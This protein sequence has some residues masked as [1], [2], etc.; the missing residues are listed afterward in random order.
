MT[1]TRKKLKIN[2]RV[3][4]FIIHGAIRARL[5]PWNHFPRRFFV[6]LSEFPS[7]NTQLI[8]ARS[9][10]QREMAQTIPHEE[11]PPKSYSNLLQRALLYFIA[12]SSA[13]SERAT[14]GTIYERAGEI[15]CRSFTHCE[16]KTKCLTALST[17]LL[18]QP[19]TEHFT[20]S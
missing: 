1:R 2:L 15:R 16:A 12:A 5:S 9:L 19:N 14:C 7:F 18:S 8:A 17:G 6:P 20:A 13:R 4:F 3:L 10:R 11:R